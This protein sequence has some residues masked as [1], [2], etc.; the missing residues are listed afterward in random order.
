MTDVRHSFEQRRHPKDRASKAALVPLHFLLHPPFRLHESPRR[1]FCGKAEAPFLV[2][3]DRPISAKPKVCQRVPSRPFVEQRP[4]QQTQ[5]QSSI[6]KAYS[7]SWCRQVHQHSLSRNMNS[8]K[9]TFNHHDP[10]HI[11]VHITLTSVNHPTRG[12]K[13]GWSHFFEFQKTNQTESLT[14]FS[15]YYV[16]ALFLESPATRGILP[17]FW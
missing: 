14:I 16:P 2:K 10:T 5:I 3:N 7:L 12:S 13:F 8:R 4:L 11:L 9:S 6:Y 17:P 15:T 1:T